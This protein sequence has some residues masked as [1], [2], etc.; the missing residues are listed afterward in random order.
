MFRFWYENNRDISNL[1]KLFFFS[2]WIER[3][4]KETQA[5]EIYTPIDC[6]PNINILVS[7]TF[8]TPDEFQYMFTRVSV[9]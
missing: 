4:N 8:D 7:G 5:Y 1:H 2:G 6:L 9:K 3:C